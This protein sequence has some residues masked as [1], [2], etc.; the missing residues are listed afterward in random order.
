M[1]EVL[2][3]IAD[4]ANDNRWARLPLRNLL[5]SVFMASN[6]YILESTLGR[7]RCMHPALPNY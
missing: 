3:L 2:M 1:Q 6:E 5:S 7:I 4:I